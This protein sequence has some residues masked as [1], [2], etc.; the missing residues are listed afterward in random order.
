MLKQTQHQ[1]QQNEETPHQTTARVPWWKHTVP[2]Y[3]F[4]VLIVAVFTGVTLIGENLL[5]YYY[6]PNSAS[7]LMGILCVAL[8]WGVGPGLLATILSCLTLIYIDLFPVEKISAPIVPF[9]WEV[10]FPVLLFAI[11]G[12]AVVILIGQR[13][14]ARRKALQAER[15]AE[16]HATELDSVNQELRQANQ[17]KDLFV[18]ITS[19]ELKTPITTI[20]GQAQLALR[21][22]QKARLSIVRI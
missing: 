6:F 1:T 22:T 20:R 5:Q 7:L 12:L 10:V 19:H 8:L 4:A 14:S 21:R 17:Y 9:N 2:G 15:L 11:A 13:E 3:V 16:K 18:S